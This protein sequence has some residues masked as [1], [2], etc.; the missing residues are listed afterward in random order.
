VCISPLGLFTGG[1]ACATCYAAA[2]LILENK[3]ADFRDKNEALRKKYQDMASNVDVVL[4]RCMD[5]I[6]GLNDLDYDIEAVGELI[7]DAW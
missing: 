1:A 5:I 7:D 6:N 2:A 4:D 3:L